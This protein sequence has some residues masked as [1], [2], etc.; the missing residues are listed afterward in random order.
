MQLQ[1]EKLFES[2][3]QEMLR[4]L[5]RSPYKGL[6]HLPDDPQPSLVLVLQGLVGRLIKDQ[7]YCNNIIESAIEK[8]VRSEYQTGSYYDLD[9]L[10]GREAFFTQLFKTSVDISMIHNGP[11][12]SSANPGFSLN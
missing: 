1:D 5:S 2:R 11:L 4:T 8:M 9:T 7:S 6:S 10:N 3:K 12:R